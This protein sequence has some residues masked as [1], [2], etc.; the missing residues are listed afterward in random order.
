MKKKGLLRRLLTIL[1]VLSMVFTSQTVMTLTETVVY[2]QDEGDGQSGEGQGGE[3]ID[4]QSGS[5]QGAVSYTHLDVY[6]RQMVSR[7]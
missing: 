2:A 7:Y 5:G 1:L 6:K 3:T 4:S